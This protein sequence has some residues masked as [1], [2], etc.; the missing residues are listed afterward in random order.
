MH[1][2]G[3]RQAASKAAEVLRK[4]PDCI[5]KVTPPGPNQIPLEKAASGKAAAHTWQ[6]KGPPGPDKT[7]GPVL[8]PTVERHKS[9]CLTQAEG[10]HNPGGGVGL[11]GQD[12]PL[13]EGM[14]GHLLSQVPSDHVLGPPVQIGVGGG[15]C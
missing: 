3:A 14:W 7:G 9:Y 15:G 8:G 2:L 5:N 11:V 10:V 4:L 13:P 12:L 1:A 6:N